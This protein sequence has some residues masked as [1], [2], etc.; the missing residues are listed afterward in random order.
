[1]EPHPKHTMIQTAKDRNKQP[2]FETRE[3]SGI[4]AAST[5]IEASTIDA[6]AKDRNKQPSTFKIS[7]IEAA[8]TRI[9]ASTSTQVSKPLSKRRSTQVPKRRRVKARQQSDD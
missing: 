6:T 8:S 2:I 7:G 3:T 1:M 9:E 5:R 4:E